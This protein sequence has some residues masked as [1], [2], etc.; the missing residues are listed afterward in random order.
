MTRVM[1]GALREWH[2]TRAIMKQHGLGWQRYR[3][4]R[5]GLT[6]SEAVV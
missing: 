3:G 2:V 5:L 4:R 1:V 6:D